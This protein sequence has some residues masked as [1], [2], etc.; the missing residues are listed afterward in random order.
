[1]LARPRST[2]SETGRVAAPVRKTS[3][4]GNSAP[5]VQL[6]TRDEQE[7][8]YR[9]VLLVGAEGSWPVSSNTRSTTR[10]G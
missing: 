4:T 9:K 1:M 5:S 6:Q 10:R 7:R 2:S 3:P 8:C